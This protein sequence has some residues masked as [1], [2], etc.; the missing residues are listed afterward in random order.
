VFS[1]GLGTLNVMNETTSR[2]T[3]E[4]E[5]TGAADAT[6]SPVA[7]PTDPHP[8]GHTPPTAHVP[9]PPPQ[10]PPA[11]APQPAAPAT[12]GW[13]TPQGSTA[14]D[15]WA[16]R[17][18]PTTSGPTSAA[19]AYAGADTATRPLPSAA[20]SGATPPPLGYGGGSGGDDGSVFST[21]SA[22]GPQQEPARKQHRGRT[23]FAALAIGAIL[24]G[25]AGA[26]TAILLDDDDAATNTPSSSLDDAAS[27]DGDANPE[28]ESAALSDVGQVAEQVL[29]S[30]VSIQA[31]TPAGT[32]GGSGVII[33]SDGQI[34]TNNHV[35]AGAAQGELQV[36]F[37]DGTTAQ[38]EVIGTDPMTDLAVI[39]AQDVSGLAAASLGSSG[40]VTVGQQVVAIGSP[41]GL[42]GTV[43]TGIV[44]ALDRTVEAGD[45]AQQGESSIFSAIQTDAPINPGNS[46]G[47]LVNMSGEVVGI[48]SAILTTGSASGSIGLGFSI[49]I[50]QARPIAEELIDNGEATH[51]QIGVD[52]GN[53]QDGTR[54]ALIGGVRPNTA[55]AEAGIEEG[56]IVTKVDDR[57]ITDGTTLVA[58][59]RSYRP[60]DEITLTILRDG[61]EIT[62]DLTLGSDAQTT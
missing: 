15:P 53:P 52:V 4:P 2:N 38:A 40:D 5:P 16:T 3:P 11:P 26:G 20:G 31:V 9:P 6:S 24:G 7:A 13:S 42:D 49:P 23:W 44:S 18:L 47:P 32:S 8:S 14:S 50:D 27:N 19:G 61:D 37:S 25:G 17:P 43:T 51:A 60:G 55:A 56:D 59:A 48:N 12:T 22:A 36:T 54:G 39:Q 45:G 35:V 28:T 33:S 57:V 58:V 1:E 29:P 21:P 30:V 10:A 46:G 34:L 41:L 62:V